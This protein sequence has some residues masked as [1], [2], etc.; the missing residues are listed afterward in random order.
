MLPRKMM[1][2]V[3][4]EL[5]LITGEQLKTA[6]QEQKQNGSKLGRILVNSGVITE[7]QMLE[8][9]EIMLGI[10]HI[11]LSKLNIDPEIIGLLPPQLIRLHKILPISKHM[12]VLTMAMADPFDQLAIDDVRMACGLDVVP[13]LAS[14]T[15]IDTAIRQYLAFRL[16]PDIEKILRELSPEEKAAASRHNL[17]TVKIDED[18]PIVRLVNS[19]LTQAVQGRCSDIH[20]EPRVEEVRVRFRL[21]GELF[22]VMNLPTSILAPV[23]SRLKIIAAMDISEKRIPQD[24]RFRI[25]I[26]GRE[27]DFRCSTLPTA[28]GEKMVLRILD[29][30]AALIRIDRLGLSSANEET[31]LS[32]A[33]KPHGMVLVTGPTGSGKTTTLYSVLNRIN[34]VDKNIIT[35]EDPVEYTLDG[36]N[37]VQVNPRAGLTFA[38]GLRSILRQDPDIIMVG[39]IR[40]QETAQLA[41]QASLTGHLV[42]S[43]LHTNSAAGTIARL[44]DIG[45]EDYLLASSLAG[46]ISQRLVR[47]LCLNCRQPYILDRKTALKLSIPEEEGREFFQPGGCN[48]CRQM[49]YSGRFAIHEIMQMTSETKSLVNRGDDSEDSLE[50]MAVRDGMASIKMDGVEKARM[51]LT[52]L[53]EVM[54]TVLM[55]G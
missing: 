13:M 32:L 55:G 37:Q 25:D 50:A 53:E 46:I 29:R 35:L 41:V 3:L 9:L 14:E 49:G 30:A 28:Y 44:K 2:E 23:V 43:T 8:T 39:E 6:L 4:V 38:S 27:I 33:T 31:L 54:K 17:Q 7:Q 5:G 36:I 48:M 47:R 52:S 19:I 1:G 45:I 22:E 21:D 20:I 42:F 34:S 12:K 11:Q 26:E 16:D 10:P 18:A 51:G 40:D 15:E 24:G